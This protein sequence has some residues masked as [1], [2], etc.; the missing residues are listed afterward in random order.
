MNGLLVAGLGL[1][2]IVVTLASMVTLREALRWW[3]EGE[4]VRDLPPTFQWFGLSQTAGQW[5]TIA[6][7]AGCFVLLA[8]ALGR[9]AGG[10]FLYAV[11][12]DAEAARL[13]GLRPRVVTF[14]AFAAGGG[15]IGLAALLNA[16]RFTDVDPKSGQGLEMQ[17]IAA[18]VVGG[19]AIA[20][21]RGK[22]WG[23]LPG[24]LILAIIG[25]ALVF[26]NTPPQWERALAGGDHPARRRRGWLAQ[27]EESRMNARRFLRPELLLL[28]ALGVEIAI[29]S[30]TATNFL[31]ATNAL[32]IVRQGTEIGL[33]ALALTPVILTGGIDLSVGSLLGLCA[34]V[35]GKLWRDAHLPAGARGRL[36]AGR[37]A[38]SA[39]G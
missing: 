27:P 39:G 22:L 5:T 10:R 13:A 17:A 34:V 25:P 8:L 23:V 7:A 20:G 1:P 26:T 35:F 36:H 19:I 4:M 2:S 11:G 16:V 38:R 31:S 9:L 6:L 15:L 14:A 21:G 12:S 28:A 30:Q 32:E 3:R 37:S 24:M 29:F 18:A 33:L